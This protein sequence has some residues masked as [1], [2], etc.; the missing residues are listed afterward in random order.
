M[1]VVVAPGKDHLGVAR[2]MPDKRDVKLDT[3]LAFLKTQVTK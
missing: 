1:Q 2:G 3:V